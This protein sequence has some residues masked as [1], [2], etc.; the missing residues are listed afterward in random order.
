V[1]VSLFHL[2]QSECAG[3]PNFVL[4]L[5]LEY[6]I[7]CVVLSFGVPVSAVMDILISET[8]SLLGRQKLGMLIISKLAVFATN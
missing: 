1:S 2:Y 5:L 3:F 4:C 7:F 6:Q 8:D